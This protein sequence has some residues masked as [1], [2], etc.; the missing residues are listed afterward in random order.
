M[1][2]LVVARADNGII[3]RDNQLP[4]HLPADLKHFKQLTTGHPIVM[5]RRTYE[6]IG[7]PLPNRRN[8]VVTRQTDWQVEGVE[9]AHSVLG[10]LELARQTAEE[11]YVIGGAEIYRQA[12]PAADTIYLTEV[13]HEAEGDTVLPDFKA[14]TTWRET[15]RERHEPDEKHAY[16]YSFVTLQRRR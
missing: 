16:A 2:A 13:H 10:A 9:V 4:W 5:G 6:S 1:I 3:G 8:I 12:L 7:K 14:D 15:S 11:V